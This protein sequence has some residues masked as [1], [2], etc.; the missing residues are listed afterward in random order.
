MIFERVRSILDYNIQLGPS[1]YDVLKRNRFTGFPIRYVQSFFKQILF[2]I[3]FMH[4]VGL[5][6]T[7]LKPENIL[8]KDEVHIFM[9]YFVVNYGQVIITNVHINAKH[10]IDY[11]FPSTISLKLLIW[12]EPL[13]MMNT[14]V[15]SLIR[16]NI[17]LPKSSPETNGHNPAICGVQGVSCWNSI[18][19]LNIRKTLQAIY[20]F[21]LKTT[22]KSTQP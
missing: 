9:S 10:I 8:L 1:L 7:D 19:V 6:H 11:I 5:T 13:S 18:R 3:G 15:P 20:F 22:I 14:T 12:E 21:S 2:S 16:D 4:A 17:G